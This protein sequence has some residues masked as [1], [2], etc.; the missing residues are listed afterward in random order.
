MNLWVE[1]EEQSTKESQWVKVVDRLLPFMMNINTAG[2]T[3]IEQ[4]IKK[5]QVLSINEVVAKM[6]PE[7]YAWMLVKIE[8]AVEKK[9]LINS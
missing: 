4:G 2:K 6:A 7:I 9:W 1:Y 8:I 3:W 5:S